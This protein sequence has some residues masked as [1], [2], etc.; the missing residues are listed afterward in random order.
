LT[1]ETRLK[2]ATN[3]EMV[4]DFDEIEQDYTNE[5]MIESINRV[6]PMEKKSLKN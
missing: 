6:I 4:I 3:P 1:Q 5:E 2:I